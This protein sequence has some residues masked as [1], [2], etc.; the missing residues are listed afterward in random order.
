MVPQA[1]GGVMS[2]GVTCFST[3]LHM[4]S[5]RSQPYTFLSRSGWVMNSTS[6]KSNNKGANR[7]QLLGGMTAAGL[8]L[9]STFARGADAAPVARTIYGKVRGLSEGPVKIFKGVPY[10][11][12]TAGAN[13]FMPPKP[14]EAWTG[15]RDTMTFGDRSPQ[16]D[17][18]TFI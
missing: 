2:I 15:V 13:R 17:V 4:V 11:A 16:T 10:G 8:I 1:S 3:L 14:P 9:P 18:V 7:R 6:N 12:S 5:G